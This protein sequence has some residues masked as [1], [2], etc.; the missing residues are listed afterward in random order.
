MSSPSLFQEDEQNPFLGPVPI[1]DQML[2]RTPYGGRLKVTLP[3]G[4]LLVV[5]LKDK[6]LIRHKKRWS[7]VR[8]LPPVW[9]DSLDT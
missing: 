8:T 2:L 7:Q 6:S 5:H 4:N 3:C 9:K 1:G